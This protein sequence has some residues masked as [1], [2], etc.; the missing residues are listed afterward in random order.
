[1]S[2]I[3][4]NNTFAVIINILNL[5]HIYEKNYYCN[6]HYRLITGLYN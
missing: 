5:N 1:M 3:M 6:T 4:K 2:F